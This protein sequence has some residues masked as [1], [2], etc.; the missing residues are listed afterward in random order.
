MVTVLVC[1]VF[2]SF[3]YITSVK[4]RVIVQREVDKL[5][6]SMIDLANSGLVDPDGEN[7]EEAV[8][9]VLCLLGDCVLADK[10]LSQWSKAIQFDFQIVNYA[11]RIEEVSSLIL[12]AQFSNLY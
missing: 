8:F 4:W 5:Y 11:E 12:I 7:P 1:Y 9:G 2:F 10:W 3:T 6:H